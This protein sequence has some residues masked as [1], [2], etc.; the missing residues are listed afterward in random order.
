MT[1][2]ESLAEAYFPAVM[3]FSINLVCHIFDGIVLHGTIIV[4]IIV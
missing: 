2:C 3:Y 4:L 1:D